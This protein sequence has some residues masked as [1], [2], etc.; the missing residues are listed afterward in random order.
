MVVRFIAACEVRFKR[1]SRLARF[2]KLSAQLCIEC[3]F[4]VEEMRI[5]YF[6]VR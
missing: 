1:A 2:L 6:V 3:V 4:Y 5:A